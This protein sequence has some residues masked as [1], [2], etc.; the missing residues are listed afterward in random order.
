MEI[1]SEYKAWRTQSMCKKAQNP[2]LAVMLAKNY[3]IMHKNLCPW[4]NY[5]KCCWVPVA[6]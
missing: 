4:L 3:C 6:T 1:R 5:G 2:Q